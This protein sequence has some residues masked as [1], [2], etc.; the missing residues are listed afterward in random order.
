[1]A[2]DERA[3][4]FAPAPLPLLVLGVVLLDIET[5]TGVEA[6]VDESLEL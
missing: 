1:M 4:E 3:L 2:E 6:A 5:V